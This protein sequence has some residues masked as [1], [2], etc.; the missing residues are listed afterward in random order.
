MA[1][2]PGEH[3]VPIGKSSL[4]T[5]SEVK[6]KLTQEQAQIW[7]AKY[8]KSNPAFTTKLLTGYVDLYPI[9]DMLIRSFFLRDFSLMIAGRGFSKSYTISLFIILYALFVPG[10]KIIVC[11]GTFR[12][13]K[14]IFKQI[15]EF[16][17]HPKAVFLRQCITKQPSHL[18]DCH[19][20]GINGS[21]IS[22][23]PLTARI[24][25]MRANLVVVDE[26]F[27]VGTEIMNSVIKPFL[28]VQYKAKE[29]AELKAAEDIL[30]AQGKLKEE[31][32][33][34]IINNK[35]IGLSSA[36]FQVEDLYK[37]YY[38]PYITAIQ[39]PDAKGVSHF[40]T[41]LS[42]EAAPDGLMNMAQID[43]AKRT[44][45]SQQFDKEYRA[46]F[47]SESGGYFSIQEILA[48]CVEPGYEPSVRL[49]GEKGKKYILAIDPNYSDSET[50]DDFAMCVL[51]LDEENRAG[52]VVHAYALSQSSITKRAQYLKYLLDSFDIVFIVVDNAGGPKFIEDCKQ[53][54]GNLPKDLTL[55]EGDFMDADS[56]KDAAN[57]YNYTSGRIVHSQVFSK[58]GW[59]RISNE[60][61]KANIEHKKIRFGSRLW[62]NA[63]IEAAK[64]VQIP[65]NLEYRKETE[66]DKKFEN[67]YDGAGTPDEKLKL[68]FSTHLHEMVELTKT[69]LSFIDA[70]TTEMGVQRFD[71]PKSQRTNR[72]PNRTRKDS[73]VALQMAS[74][75]MK[76]Y[77]DIVDASSRSMPTFRPVRIGKY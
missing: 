20:V 76:A 60:T 15:E 42:Y 22:A 72:G 32:R 33:T 62:N 53:F 69:Q 67:K 77:F 14:L 74:W 41:R 43:D 39:D 19:E 47:L 51:E 18:T 71:L 27:L 57:S 7:F 21:L 9:Q 58:N 31:D 40:V 24:R 50:A 48:A 4:E 23:V 11:S 8:C 55:I 38:L 16:I 70:S 2:F 73:Y 36:S 1:W 28:N 12:Q 59:I 25:G 17:S 34:P 26:L 6:G 64:K 65:T 56:I 13:S 52:T 44:S 49:E 30:I 29:Q 54:L 45:S 68:D 35:L 66:D 5:L 75:G 3:L 46:I 10:V 63:Q 61:L 37:A